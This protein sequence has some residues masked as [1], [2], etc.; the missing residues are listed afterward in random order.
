MGDDFVKRF[1]QYLYREPQL[2]TVA[3]KDF[4]LDNMMF[5][6]SDGRVIVLDWQTLGLG[7]PMNDVSYFCGTSF[8]DPGRTQTKRGNE[9]FAMMAERPARMALELD[10]LSLL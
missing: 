8:A 7:S 5:D 3:H 4:R 6:A 10:S 2:T 9:M 1:N